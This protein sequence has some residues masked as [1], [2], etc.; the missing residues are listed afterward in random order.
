MLQKSC[1]IHMFIGFLWRNSIIFFNSAVILDFFCTFHCKLVWFGLVYDVSRHFQQYFSYIVA[2]SCIGEGNL[3]TRR[4]P[5]TCRKSLTNF[6]TYC[7]V[8]YTSQYKRFELT[9][10]VVKGTVCT[11]SC[12]SNY[13]ANTTIPIANWV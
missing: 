4:K 12:K 10:L 3:S 13:H 11:G 5:P 9:T 2:V 1:N 7:C 6:I 8:K